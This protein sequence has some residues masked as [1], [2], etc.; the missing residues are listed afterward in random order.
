MNTA[1]KSFVTFCKLVPVRQGLSEEDQRPVSVPATLYEQR[2]RPSLSLV[3]A[4][5]DNC[6]SMSRSA[7]IV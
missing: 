7:S 6:L 4:S 1:R 5:T 3:E 2:M